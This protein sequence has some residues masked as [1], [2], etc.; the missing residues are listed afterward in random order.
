MKKNINACLSI[1]L[2]LVSTL[3]F[4]QAG[5]TLRSHL[6][7]IDS[8]RSRLPIEK[9][10]IQMDKPYYTLGDTLRFK[11]YL[12]NADYLTPSIRSGLL[13]LELDDVS[14]R[15]V[16]RIMVP[17]SSGLSWGDMALNKEEL[18]DGSYTLRAYTNWMLNFGE[19][20][21]FKKALYISALSPPAL[22][23]ADFKL[24]TVSGKTK[25]L[26]SLRFT[27]MDKAPLR[28]K[29]MQLKVMNGR[30][31]LIK[32]NASTGMDGQ[33]QVGFELADKTAVNKLTIQLHQTGKDADT[34][35]LT[36]PVSINRPEKTD[37]QFMPEGGNLV[38]G[39]TT[40]VG[41]K[42][43]GED[44]KGTTISGTIQNSKHQQIA[45]FQ[46][47]HIGMGSF[48]FTPQENE[49]Y[50]AMV[51]LPDRAVKS[52]PLPL[53]QNTGTVLRV[54]PKG[55]DSLTLTLAI[56]KTNIPATCYLTGQ[57]RG[58]VCYAAAIK[59]TEGAQII[60]KTI[61]TN[62][63]PT[64]I[65]RFTLLDQANRPLNERVVYIEHNDNLQ[66]TISPNKPGY[67]TRDSIALNIIVKNKDGK[68]VQG[69]FSLAVSDNNQVRTDST[70]SNI[71]N[72]LL[73]S[74]DL[75]GTVEEPGWYFENGGEQKREQALDN[76]LLTQGWVG[77]G[78][79]DI[80]SAQP[81]Q[82]KFDAEKEFT[83]QGR[84][85]NL[86]NKG[87]EHSQVVLIGKTPAVFRDT[88]TDKDGRFIFKKL[89]PID[90]AEFKLEARNKNGKEFNVGIEME[91]EFAPPVFTAVKHSTPW[92]VNSDTAQLNNANTKIAQLKA[93]ANYQDQG[94]Q[95]KEVVIKDKK[96]IKD[97]HNLNGPGEAD[98]AIDE[99]DILKAK[100]TTL[101]DLLEQKIKGFHMY[102]IWQPTKLCK[103][104]PISTSYVLDG[105][106]VVFII[107]GVS[108]NKLFNGNPMGPIKNPNRFAFFKSYMDYF[109]AEEIKGIE[110]M[111]SDIYTSSYLFSYIGAAAVCP[112]N[113]AFIEITTRSGHGPFMKITP[114]T[115]LYKPLPFTLPKQFYSPKYTVSNHNLAMGT[116]LRSTIYWQPNIVTDE[117]GKA[118]V[119]FFA[120]D[121]LA[122]YTAIIEGT[123]LSGNLGY[124]RKKI[125][126]ASK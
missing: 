39:F 46:S 41:F 72:N 98:Q 109:T 35:N 75:K 122:D 99:Q 126:I 76:L 73:F 36:I 34:A 51:N 101:G 38:A 50:T 95:L 12:L 81:I 87:V 104:T 100:K 89:F 30:R 83:V 115:Y 57:A 18:P 64:G 55:A 20:Y 60:K 94:H 15:M 106:L 123:D 22:V 86:L 97:S 70:G 108:L 43:I 91:H 7:L 79:K 9:L 92:Y 118:T 29:D 74:S 42:A 14:G 56:T 77:Y 23:K 96:I 27:G 19:D 1:L 125:K 40:R 69:I 4:G 31:N 37:V 93:E 113:L 26:A 6:G 71:L 68:P 8:I 53:V 88:I 32:D 110:V 2:M 85:T 16:K 3:V 103:S 107:D 49:S 62:L 13:Y 120:A 105:Q 45:S 48:E 121:K 24:D 25:V 124:K 66:V 61:A 21:I 5:N 116:D 114:G 58:I 44:A 117:N 102:G 33:M 52:Y 65:A 119:S 63:F 10:Y 28:L 17:V 82:P 80:F 112:P 67:T 84:V 90:T 59:F 111:R 47:T 54:D 78:W 11:G